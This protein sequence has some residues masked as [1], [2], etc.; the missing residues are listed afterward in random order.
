MKPKTMYYYLFYKFYRLFESFETTRWLTDVKAV[1]CII[2]IEIWI[3][4]SLL[5]YYDVLTHRHIIFSFFSLTVLI[6][7]VILLLIKWVLFWKDDR[8]RE[9]VKEFDKWPKRKNQIGGW[10][11]AGLTLLIFANLILSLYLD[12]PVGGWK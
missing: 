4:F 5:N 10:V 8:W 6:P 12:P 1:I 9:Y 11:V 7:L 3:L 2:S